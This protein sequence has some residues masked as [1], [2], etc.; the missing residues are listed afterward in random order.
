M[1]KRVRKKHYQ[2][3][4]FIEL[5]KSE[6]RHPFLKSEFLL[7]SEYA[8]ETLAEHYDSVMVNFEKS[9]LDEEKADVVLADESAPNGSVPQSDLTAGLG[10][11]A[12]A[13]SKEVLDGTYD[14]IQQDIP[15]KEKA[16]QL[17]NHS[18]QLMEYILTNPPTASLI[19]ECSKPINE[20]TD[21]ILNDVQ[22]AKYLLSIISPNYTTYTHCAN[23]AIKS[24][25]IAKHILGERDKELYQ[26]LGIAFFLH[27]I[28][29]SQLDPNILDTS[30]PLSDEALKQIKSH[31]ER[32]VELLR[33]IGVLTKTMQVVIEQHHERMDGS[34]Y[35]KGL[36]GRA[37]HPYAQICALADVYDDLTAK[38]SDSSGASVFDALKRMKDEMSE[39]FEPKLLNSFIKFFV[40]ESRG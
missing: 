7:N 35:P 32:G 37:I 36:K 40:Q 23:T 39:H 14:L 3:G 4:M 10:P 16:L 21:Y 15:S 34:G 8:V 22:V 38:R 26:E 11:L 13:V 9:Q 19:D 5:D 1:R 30:A 31:P 33:S 27:D 6:M 29:K 2:V 28:G 20:M 25:L 12:N 18:S 17:F 24:L